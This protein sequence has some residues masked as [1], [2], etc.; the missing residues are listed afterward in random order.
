MNGNTPF[1]M[2]NEEF[3]VLIDKYIERGSQNTDDLDLEADMFFDAVSDFMD[4]LSEVT[5]EI[6]G[7]WHNGNFQ[8]APKGPLPRD[9][10]ISG[11][12]IALPGMTFIIQPSNAAS[13]NGIY[14]EPPKA[15][16]HEEQVRFL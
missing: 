6:E 14:R 12:R 3:K 8:L 7:T 11:N 4:G 15:L 2:S 16:A 13:P 10:H 1:G 5:L 9:V